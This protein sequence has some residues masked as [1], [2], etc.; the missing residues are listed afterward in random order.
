M[1]DFLP[2]VTDERVRLIILSSFSNPYFSSL[3]YSVLSRQYIIICPSSPEGGKVQNYLFR[4]LAIKIVS[5]VG[6]F[7]A[8]VVYAVQQPLPFQDREFTIHT[9]KIIEEEK[10]P[11]HSVPFH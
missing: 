5:V 4:Y 9:S 7:D 3:F 10:E 11:L 2:F 6:I 1:V 8:T